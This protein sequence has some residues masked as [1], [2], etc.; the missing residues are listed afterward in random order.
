[1]TEDQFKSPRASMIATSRTPPSLS[2]RGP[3]VS[4]KRTTSMPTITV[5]EEPSTAGPASLNLDLTSTTRTFT[6][7]ALLEQHAEL[8]T[9][10]KLKLDD[11]LLFDLSLYLE[12]RAGSQVGGAA[13]KKAPG[14]FVISS[15][16]SSPAATYRTRNKIDRTMAGADSGDILPIVEEVPSQQPPSDDSGTTGCRIKHSKSGDLTPTARR[17]NESDD[18]SLVT[19]KALQVVKKEGR[20]RSN[21]TSILPAEASAFVEELEQSP[22]P[23]SATDEVKTER[24]H[25]D[26]PKAAGDDDEGGVAKKA[27]KA[28]KLLK[29]KKSK[30]RLNA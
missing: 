15:P 21:T 26:A 25:K 4:I 19:G 27:S 23:K 6:P 30:E 22:T 17:K 14:L 11:S 29:S 5:N 9:M 12:P 16:Q 8:F 20:P 13:D 10:K 7:R 24:R 3:S 18:S 2:P 28:R 1:V